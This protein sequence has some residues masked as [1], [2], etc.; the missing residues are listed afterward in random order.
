MASYELV[1]TDGDFY[2][3]LPNGDHAILLYFYPEGDVDR[4]HDTGERMHGA[5][6]DLYQVE[7]YHSGDEFTLEGVALYRADGVHVVKA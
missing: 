7:D 1:K 5:L 4:V 2:V 6:Y 3:E